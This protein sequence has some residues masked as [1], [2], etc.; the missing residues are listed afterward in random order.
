VTTPS[1]SV[2]P[3]L[4]VAPHPGAV[5][6][7]SR[8]FEKCLNS[9]RC[10]VACASVSAVHELVSSV[11]PFIVN[12]KRLVARGEE[13]EI[14]LSIPRILRGKEIRIDFTDGRIDEQFHVQISR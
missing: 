10:H 14:V 7:F 1:P 8:R 12:L 5:P 13:I 3:F 2:Q 4:K 6:D 11:E 9:W